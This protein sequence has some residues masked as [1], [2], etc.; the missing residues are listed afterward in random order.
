MN[1]P[2]AGSIH[3]CIHLTQVF[4][5]CKRWTISQLVEADRRL[6]CAYF[7]VSNMLYSCNQTSCCGFFTLRSGAV[8]LAHTK[9]CLIRLVTYFLCAYLCVCVACVCAG[10]RWALCADYREMI[11]ALETVQCCFARAKLTPHGHV[12]LLPHCGICKPPCSQFPSAVLTC[13]CHYVWEYGPRK[14]NALCPCCR[15]IPSCP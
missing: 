3:L 9:C 6:R 12:E 15:W 4:P 8:L 2:V 5:V 13:W 7:I 10:T 11:F 1:N 14:Q